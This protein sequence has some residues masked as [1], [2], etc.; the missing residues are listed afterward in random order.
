MVA[1]LHDVARTGLAVPTGLAS[2]E[3]SRFMTYVVERSDLNHYQAYRMSRVFNEMRLGV[4]TQQ[5]AAFDRVAEYRAT[6]GSDR[7]WD[8]LLREWITVENQAR[9]DNAARFGVDVVYLPTPT[10]QI[11]ANA[12]KQ[13]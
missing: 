6:V 3:I 4:F 7:G 8:E 11:T 10:S 12:T 5:C 13:S 9:A 1:V 2:S